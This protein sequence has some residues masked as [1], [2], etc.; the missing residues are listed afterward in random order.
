MKPNG[1]PHLRAGGAAHEPGQ[2]DWAPG[3]HFH[4]WAP[5]PQVATSQ[6][7]P[8]ALHNWQRDHISAA[9]VAVAVAVAISRRRHLARHGGVRG[10]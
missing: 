3:G 8:T 9:S 10:S 5:Q 7:G 1:Y 2:A 6:L 4:G